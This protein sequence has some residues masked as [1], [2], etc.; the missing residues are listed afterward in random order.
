MAREASVIR[1]LVL[2]KTK[3]T[4]GHKVD[5]KVTGG[6]AKASPGTTETVAKAREGKA[7]EGREKEMGRVAKEIL[8]AR[9]WPVSEQ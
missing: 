5:T 2:D 7:R 3:V 1:I 6:V 4:P 9:G 8:R